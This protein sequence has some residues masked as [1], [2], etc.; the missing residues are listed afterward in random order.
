MTKKVYNVLS[1][2]MTVVDYLDYC[3]DIIVESEFSYLVRN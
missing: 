2:V 3:N 1:N